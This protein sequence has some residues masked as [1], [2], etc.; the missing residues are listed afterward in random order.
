MGKI[1]DFFYNKNDII[2]VLLILAIAGFIIYTKINVIMDY[3]EKL[4]ESQATATTQE[5]SEAADTS[6]AS[7]ASSASADTTATE[8]SKTGK[9][10]SITIKDSDTSVSVSKK[11][12]DAGIVDSAT[13]FEGYISN[14]G[15]A[16][17]IQS[18][19]FKI[20]QGSSFEK[21][22]NTITN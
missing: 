15:K 6:A 22:L 9:T 14:M 8:A 19:T 17:K 4:A 10:V 7:E 1:K 12:A 11:L 3:P 18:G 13:E 5:T 21:I 20:E 16:E 2:I